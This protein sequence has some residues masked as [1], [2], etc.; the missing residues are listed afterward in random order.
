MAR[1]VVIC[2]PDNV[3]FDFGADTLSPEAEGYLK[4]VADLAH[5]SAGGPANRFEDAF[6]KLKAELGERI[7]VGGGFR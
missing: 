4:L 7:N 5:L 6:D 3:M 1:G 2:L